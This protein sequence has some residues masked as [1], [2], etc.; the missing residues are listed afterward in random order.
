MPADFLLTQE[1]FDALDELIEAYAERAAHRA[2]HGSAS[3]DNVESKK[4]WARYH[5]T[6][7]FSE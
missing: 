6:G 5:L 1:Q 2:I 3:N 7:R 4:N